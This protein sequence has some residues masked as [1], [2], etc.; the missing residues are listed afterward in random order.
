M[1]D[2]LDGVP[3]ATHE[4]DPLVAFMNLLKEIGIRVDKLER[5][6]PQRSMSITGPTGQGI[7]MDSTGLQAVGTS[8]KTVTYIQ[9]N[10]GA[11]V[12]LDATGQPVARFGPLLS[13]PG[14][15]GGEIWNST[16]STWVQLLVNGAISWSGISGKPATFP[17]SGH[18][19]PGTDINSTVALAEGSAYA[20]NNNVA[21]STFYAVWVGND[22]GNHLG[23]NTSS[24]RYKQ[25]VRDYTGIDPTKVLQLRPV[26]FDRKPVPVPPPDGQEGPARMVPGAVDEYGL[27]AEEVNELVPEIVLRFDAGDGQGPLIDGVRYDLL[28]L[29]LLD[30]VKDHQ[31]Q[32]RNQ[33]MKSRKQNRRI[34]ALEAAVRAFGGTL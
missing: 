26:I 4:P 32:L 3:R 22:T 23:K 1:A 30:V 16:T 19:H 10:D 24:I 8:G 33:D 18:T 31:R 6:A 12:T 5:A 17:P 7:K 27:I 28:A 29:A 14:Q 2:D 25:N 20:F 13:A 34:A 21:G 15:Y 11:F 9:T